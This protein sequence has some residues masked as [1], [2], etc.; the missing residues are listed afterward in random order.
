MFAWND[1]GVIIRIMAKKRTKE[2]I[3]IYKKDGVIQWD[4]LI[5]KTVIYTQVGLGT[6]I[7]EDTLQ[8]TLVVDATLH[9]KLPVWK[10]A[11]E[12]NILYVVQYV[13]EKKEEPKQEKVYDPLKDF[14]EYYRKLNPPKPEPAP[15][16]P[17][18]PYEPAI[19][20]WSERYPSYPYVGDP[21]YLWNSGPMWLVTD[22]S[23]TYMGGG[24]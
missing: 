10:L 12:V 21:P 19:P 17:Y 3:E 5:G 24:R 20:P 13:K 8:D 18:V 14:E 6:R 1:G 4:D 7:Q 23:F 22:D 15:Y 9:L 2:S 16:R 11:D